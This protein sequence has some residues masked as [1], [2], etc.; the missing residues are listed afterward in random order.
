MQKLITD[1]GVKKIAISGDDLINAIVES[2]LDYTIEKASEYE[3]SGRKNK[4]SQIDTA[5][6]FEGNGIP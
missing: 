1:G 2:L 3:Y 4:L 6:V 5:L